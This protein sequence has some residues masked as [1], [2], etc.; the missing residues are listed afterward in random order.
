M[1]YV[2]NYVLHT[3]EEDFEKV[4]R[5]SIVFRTIRWDKIEMLGKLEHQSCVASIQTVQVQAV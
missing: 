3:V 4:V 2:L 5:T 1:N